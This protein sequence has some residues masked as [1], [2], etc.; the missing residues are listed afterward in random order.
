MRLP[1]PRRS[2]RYG[3]TLIELLVVIAIIAVLIALLLPAVQSAREAA[4]RA[5]CV[6]NLKQIGLAAYNYESTHGAFPMGNRGA[7]F[8]Y[9][10]AFGTACAEYIG[11]SAFVFIL[12]YVEQSTQMNAYNLQRAYDSYANITGM[13]NK[14]ASYLCPSDTPASPDPTGDIQ[15]PQASYG[16]S[17]GTL[18]TIAFNWALTA[19][20]DPSQPYFSSCNWGGGDGMFGPEASVRIAA[21]TDGTSN[22]FFFGEQTQFRNEPA[23]SNFSFNMIATYFQGPPWT[24]SPFWPNDARVTSGTTTVARLNSPPDTIGNLMN[25]Y[26]FCPT[27]VPTCPL[28][29]DP[30]FQNLGQIAFH[31][32]HPG[33]ANF[34]MADGSVRFV[35]NGIG[36]QVYRALGTRAGGEIV[37]SDRY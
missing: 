36:L 19:Y 27:G 9:S 22:T 25:Q 33:G 28:S 14:V 37:S 32:L 34:S 12:P 3:F 1:I 24:G 6:N 10:P 5:Q 31:S 16:T 23:G 20:P 8:Y 7:A 29:Q 2:Y 17:R 35:K 18:D 4:R 30:L 26:T 21:V 15:P 13:A 11:H